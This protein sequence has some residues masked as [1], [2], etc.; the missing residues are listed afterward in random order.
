M[1]R[2][3]ADVVLG[4]AISTEVSTRTSLIRMES[5]GIHIGADSLVYAEDYFDNGGDRLFTND[6]ED[7]AVTE[8]FWVKPDLEVGA[9]VINDA[10]GEQ[11]PKIDNG[12][13]TSTVFTHT[14]DVT[15]ATETPEDGGVKMETNGNVTLMKPTTGGSEVNYMMVQTIQVD[16]ATGLEIDGEDA[17]VGG[18][19][20]G[21]GNFV[22]L[23]E[24][25]PATGLFYEPL[26]PS[27][28]AAI[29]TVLPAGDGGNLLVEGD[30]EVLGMTYT[31]GIDNGGQ[32]ITNV[33]DGEDYS[34]A[35][36][37]GQLQ[38]VDH[39]IRE[40][41]TAVA[42][43]LQDQI[44]DLEDD[45]SQV[46]AMAA[47]FSAL[48]P[49][50]RVAGNTQISLGYGYYDGEN[51]LAAGVFHYVNDNILLNAG[52]SGAL[53]GGEVAARAGITFGF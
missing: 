50:D 24:V 27:E 53:D 10:S 48:V 40:D 19:L 49:N 12:D 46:G 32:R 30:A 8:T 2:A 23:G 28:L 38:A 11:L 4:T 33:A 42:N 21:Y 18:Y 45:I 3:S 47:A 37:V 51:A 1:T 14:K 29:T 16:N 43:H 36:T 9:P 25:N 31:N 15:I 6:G 35:A 39:S 5:D 22:N 26:S 52:A 41:F 34:D 7:L 44:D 20:D 17:L 13:E